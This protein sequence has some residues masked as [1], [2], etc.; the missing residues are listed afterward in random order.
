[1]SAILLIEKIFL[2]GVKWIVR[3]VLVLSI[4]YGLVV[5]LEVFLICR[6]LAVD[7]NPHVDGRCADQIVSY[8][9]LEILGL[10]IDLTILVAPL[11]VIAKLQMDWRRKMSIAAVFSVGALV[12]IITGLRIQALHMVNAQDFIYSKGYLGLLSALGASLG[13][14][15]CCIPGIYR[16]YQRWRKKLLELASRLTHV[17]ERSTAVFS[18]HPNEISSPTNMNDV[19]HTHRGSEIWRIFEY[20]HF[21]AY[22]KRAPK[23]VITDEEMTAAA[24]ET[25]YKISW[26]VIPGCPVRY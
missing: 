20:R 13:I 7:W 4:L 2:R 8:L 24:S 3:S 9:V 25:P 17:N 1:M 12:F 22:F 19:A 15:F 14:T 18:R 23:A 11:P 21:K 16:G 10:L 6:P 26:P 5:I